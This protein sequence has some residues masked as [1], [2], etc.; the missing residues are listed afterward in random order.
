[1]LCGILVAKSIFL[2]AAISKK[3]KKDTNALL[4]FSAGCR[5]LSETKQ[6]EH[7]KPKMLEF[8]F[9]IVAKCFGAPKVWHKWMCPE[10]CNEMEIFKNWINLIA[11]ASV[12]E[13]LE[14]N[15]KFN[16]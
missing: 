4:P 9:L 16:L 14:F 7:Q 6:T 10:H 3:T 15:N 11:L 12:P 13:I 1:M 2:L 8:E 5:K